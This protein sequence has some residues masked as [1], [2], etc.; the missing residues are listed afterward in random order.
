MLNLWF[1]LFWFESNKWW[2]LQTPV[3]TFVVFANVW[4]VYICPLWS[5][6]WLFGLWR[7]ES[8]NYLKDSRYT[9]IYEQVLHV[10]F[11]GRAKKFQNFSSNIFSNILGDM[12]SHFHM[13]L[14]ALAAYVKEMIKAPLFDHTPSKI[15]NNMQYYSWF[16]RFKW[17]NRRDTFACN[18]SNGESHYV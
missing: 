9:I 13:A 14:Q 3:H 12:S 18:C 2:T 16:K 15:L 7:I 1:Y 10:S 8:Q 6:M 5:M 4:S 17:C 11:R